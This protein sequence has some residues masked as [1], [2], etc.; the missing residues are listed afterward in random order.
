MRPH[1]NMG[2]RKLES[3]CV[4]SFSFLYPGHGRSR[5]EIASD[6]GRRADGGG[7]V[8]GGGGTKKKHVDRSV[9]RR[10]GWA[11]PF[12]DFFRRF[13]LLYFFIRRVSFFGGGSATRGWGGVGLIDRATNENGGN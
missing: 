11:V 8:R 9:S 5:S 6:A 2:P 7:E 10:L 12:L 1:R 3:T 13:W 4:P